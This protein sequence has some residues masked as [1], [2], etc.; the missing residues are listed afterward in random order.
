MDTLGFYF[1][2]G[3]QHVTYLNGLD[4]FYFIIALVLPF[5]FKQAKKLVWWVT[6]F[7]LGHSLS[8]IGN[9]YLNLTFSAYWI[10]LLIPITIALSCL[11]IVLQKS[12][13]TNWF[14]S[15]LT[16]LFGII[17]GFG[18]GRFFSMMVLPEDAGTSLFSFAL[19]IEAAQ[20]CIVLCV[21]CL[22]FLVALKP[23]WLRLWQAT[24]GMIIFFVAVIMIV[25]RI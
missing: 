18:F 1:S 23:K 8:L 21:L 11:P 16:L 14:A 20:L 15:G 22:N 6:L 3:F 9:Y 12:P 25:E 13:S 17:H 2:F 24:V 10:E 19:G 7:T 4:H 5:G